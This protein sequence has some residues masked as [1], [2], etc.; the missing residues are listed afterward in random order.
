MKKILLAFLMFPLFLRGDFLEELQKIDLLLQKGQYKEA[1]QK[2]KD[3]IQTEIS[4]EDKSSLKNLL[5]VI[6]KKIKSE[7]DNLA[8]RIFNNT[9][10][11]NFTT[12]EAT[13]G[14]DAESSSTGTFA[15][16]GDVL[17]DASKYQEYVNVEKEVLASGNP[18]NVYTLSTI[19]MKSGLYERA[20]N[21]GLKTKDVRTVYN[22][23]LG[24]RLIGKYDIAIKQYQK[25]LS[26]NPSHLNSLLGLGL[27]YRGRGDKQNAIKYLQKYLNA[28]GTNPNVSKTIQYLSR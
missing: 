12:D 2:G 15:F 28:G 4:E 23:A 6:E 1:L 24:A 26:I 8:D 3:L 20:M 22:S 5:S 25:V 16:P 11:I 10:E 18:D 13:E 27:S 21:L 17:N 9:G 19:Y 14:E 7:S